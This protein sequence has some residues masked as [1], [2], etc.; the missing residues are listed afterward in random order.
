LLQQY[1]TDIRDIP[2]LDAKREKEL[3]SIIHNSTDEK[4]VKDAKEEMTNANLRIVIKLA[5]KYHNRIKQHTDY[6]VS[7]MDLVSEGNIGLM[8]AVE[9]FDADS[10]DNRF[11]TYAA[12]SICRHIDQCVK[13]SRFIRVPYRHHRHFSEYDKAM[14]EHGSNADDD[15]LRKEMGVTLNMLKMI[16]SEHLEH[17][18]V[19]DEDYDAQEF[20]QNIP[21]VDQK[22]WECVDGIDLRE[23]LYAKIKELKEDDQDIIF[24]KFFG[25]K[26]VT[27]NDLAK[28]AGVTKQAID[29]RYPKAMQR[30]R[31]NVLADL[32]QW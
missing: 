3:S 9:L 30:L 13:D 1:M 18:V 26:H 16:Q 31:V 22:S 21:S 27:L 25:N 19:S 15:T 4:S 5:I 6:N 29:Q 10:F 17:K 32:K 14:K 23:Y 2:L 24:F 8:R 12:M 28:K 7:L 11:A 20:I